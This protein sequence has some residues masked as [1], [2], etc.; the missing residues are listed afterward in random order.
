VTKYVRH[1]PRTLALKILSMDGSMES[2]HDY[3]MLLGLAAITKHPKEKIFCSTLQMS[4]YQSN[5]HED[6]FV[7]A[8]LGIERRCVRI[9]INITH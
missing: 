7:A 4:S 8:K 2:A 6:L 5:K 3:E 1:P 9:P